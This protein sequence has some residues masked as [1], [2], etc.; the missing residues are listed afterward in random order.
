MVDAV[1]LLSNRFPKE[2]LPAAD[3][4]GSPRALRPA[5]VLTPLRLPGAAPQEPRR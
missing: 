3:R 4:P 5:T 1:I 2:A